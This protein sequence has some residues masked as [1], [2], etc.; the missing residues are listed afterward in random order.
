MWDEN[1]N[2][3]AVSGHIPTRF[4]GAR[5]RRADTFY[6]VTAVASRVIG[7]GFECIGTFEYTVKRYREHVR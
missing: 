5:L 4:Y 2:D 7:V 6:R 1:A 3:R